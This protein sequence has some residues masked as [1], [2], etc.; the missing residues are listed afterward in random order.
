MH[1]IREDART[2]K[3]GG[4][5]RKIPPSKGDPTHHIV[6][7]LCKL[8]YSTT[9]ESRLVGQRQK[10]IDV[11]SRFVVRMTRG[12]LYVAPI[13]TR[14]AK[15][16][17]GDFTVLCFGF[18]LCVFLLS[19]LF[20]FRTIPPSPPLPE[21]FSDRVPSYQEATTTTGRE[22]ERERSETYNTLALVGKRVAL[23]GGR[24]GADGRE[25]R[26][27]EGKKKKNL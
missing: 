7:V 26:K 15:K 10:K 18:D 19:L 25:R 27:G 11:N 17:C 24:G 3:R 2:Q 13:E 21:S 9:V 20:P 8:P 4:K 16:K 12:V 1:E 5:I 6:V 23:P 14:R 22:K